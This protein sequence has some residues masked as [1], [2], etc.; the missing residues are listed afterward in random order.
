MNDNNKI[1]N[2]ILIGGLVIVSLMIPCVAAAPPQTGHPYMLFHDIQEIPGYQFSTIQPWNGYQ[3]LVLRSA[4]GSL[5]KN[6][7]G[8]LGSYD[9]VGYRGGFA[10]DLGLAYQITKKPVYALK[11]REALLNLNVGTVS[12]KVDKANALGAYSLAYDFI[13]PTLDTTNNTIIRDK[14]ATLADTV[15]K[16]LNDNGITRNYVSF[17]DYHGQAYPMMGIA[18]AALADYTNPNNLALSS[19]PE[20]WYKVGTDYLFVDDKL[21]SYGRSLFSFG[22]DETS[23]KYL[24]GAYKSYVTEDFAWWLQVYNYT[25][26]ENPFEK[27]PAAKQAFT[28]ELWEELPNGYSSNYVTNGNTKWTYNKGF[29]NLLDDQTKSNI[30]NYDELLDA[31]TILPY[32]RTMGEVSPGI[33]YCVYGNYASISRTYP[34]TTSHLDT[35]S[36]LQVFRENWNTDSDWLSL[37][38][39]NTITTSNRDSAHMDQLSFEYYSRGDLL[40]ADAGEIR[41]VLDEPYGTNDVSHNTIAIENPRTSFPVSPWSGSTSAGIYKGDASELTTPATVDTVV[42]MPWIQLLQTNVSITNVMAGKWLAKTSL[43]SPVN[44]ERTIL[45]PDSDYFI[46]I[47]RM[48]GTEPWIYRNIF[49]PTSLTITPTVDTNSDGVYAESEVGHVNGALTIGSTPYNWQSLP[50]KTETT[51]GI[52]ANSLTWTTTNPYGKA[53]TMN[54]FSSPS[55]EILVEKNVGRVGGYDAKSEVFNPVIWFRTPSANSEYRVTALLSSYSTEQAKNAQEIAVTG[56]GHAIKVSSSS[57]VDYIYTGKGISSFAGFTTDADTVFIRQRGDNVQVTLLG[58]SYLK[59]QNDPWIS[60]SKKADFL[61]A[62]RE[63]GTTDYR[64]QGEPD[65]RGDIFQQPVDSNKIEKRTNSN[66][67]QKPMV[68]SDI[69]AVS[70]E[71]SEMILVKLGKIVLSIF[72]LKTTG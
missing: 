71:T 46:V 30:L 1:R 65:L 23:G 42:Q 27:Y 57:S 22:F 16:D 47:D 59:Y 66:E 67:Q 18:G 32:T 11:A 40:L 60:L 21:H 72:T 10:R 17:A 48:Q 70:E 33:L 4:D 56:T 43:S 64:I 41:N 28:S 53:V 55:S 29:V 14:L 68:K 44:Y 49:R 3:D 51:T 24:N 8:N 25:Y 34:A 19:T 54:L 2:V 58:G 9:R 12:E 50:Y 52:T 62:N 35:T 15:Y 37:V 13:Q 5:S 20:D 38:T 7:A 69:N 61:T 26:G 39:F 6:F 45:Y 63:K 36:I 31:S